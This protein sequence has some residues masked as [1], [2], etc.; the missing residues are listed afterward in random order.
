MVQMEVYLC[1]PCLLKDTYVHV[2]STFSLPN[3][4]ILASD[5]T[6]LK[7]HFQKSQI[8]IQFQIQ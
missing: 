6:L 1:L 8:T 4:Y 2:S 3:L 7:L 5:T